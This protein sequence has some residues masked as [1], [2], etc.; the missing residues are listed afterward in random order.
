MNDLA[1]YIIVG[2]LE[3]VGIT[4]GMKYIDTYIHAKDEGFEKSL[5]LPKYIIPTAAI[6]VGS[7]LFSAFSMLLN[8]TD[9]VD[10]L[11]FAVVICALT[12]GSITDIK[13]KL[14][15]NILSIAMIALWLIGTVL[16]ILLFGADFMFEMVSS[17]IGGLFGGGLLLI[18]RLISRNGMGMG[19]VK[20]MFAVGLLLKFDRTFGLLFW[21]LILSL[22]VGIGLMIFKK[23]KKTYTIC[24]APFFLSGAVISVV[25]EF[26]SYMVYGGVQ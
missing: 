15:P 18:G 13:L 16:D 8:G 2:I 11:K 5:F 4:A 6:C 17:L 26:I 21:A 1:L 19:D 20:I 22:V 12:L 10:V 9:S 3:A 7:A 24:M 23:V 25:A 14:I